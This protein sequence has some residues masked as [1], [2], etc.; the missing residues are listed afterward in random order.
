MSNHL[1]RATDHPSPLQQR[2]DIPE[3]HYGPI[4]LKKSALGTRPIASEQI[5]ARAFALIPPAA[6]LQPASASPIPEVLGGGC[7]EELVAG[8]AW[9]SQA[10]AIELEDALQVTSHDRRMSSRNESAPPSA[11]R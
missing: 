10:Q 5:A 4:V 8:A 2:A 3:G 9:S 7:E 11:G 6:V 1:S